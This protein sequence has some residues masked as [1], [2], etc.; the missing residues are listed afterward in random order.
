MYQRVVMLKNAVSRKAL[1]NKRQEVVCQQID[2][3]RRVHAPAHVREEAASLLRKRPPNHDP[4]STLLGAGENALR[5]ATISP[6]V[7]KAIWTNEVK[8]VL[9]S[10]DD[11]AP[12]VVTASDVLPRPL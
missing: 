7:R 12:H 9:I 4:A 3:E 5:D 11:F 2:A 10:P 1:L 8:F 6:V